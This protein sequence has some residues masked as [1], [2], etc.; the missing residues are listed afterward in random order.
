M[1]ANLKPLQGEW[2]NENPLSTLRANTQQSHNFFSIFSCNLTNRSNPQRP[3][4]RV[5]VRKNY[6]KWSHCELQI[7]NGRK[8]PTLRKWY[9]NLWNILDCREIERRKELQ[10]YRVRL[11]FPFLTV[12]MFV[13]H[14]I[15]FNEFALRLSLEVRSVQSDQSI[16][17]VSIL[18]RMRLNAI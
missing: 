2:V 13:C 4:R 3:Q 9:E 16:L 5:R 14:F 6:L 18:I 10:I 17:C 15:A 11:W 8:N 12:C 1:L 7:I